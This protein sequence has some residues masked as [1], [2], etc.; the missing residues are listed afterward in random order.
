MLMD[1]FRIII[2]IILIILI[3]III[4]AQVFGARLGRLVLYMFLW[5]L[6]YVVCVVGL[7]VVARAHV[8]KRDGQRADVVRDM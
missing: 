8:I 3:I 5:L 1:Y 4:I 7:A 2:I 6:E